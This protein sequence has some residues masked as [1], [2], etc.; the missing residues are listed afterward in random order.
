VSS[1]W[2]VEKSN[3]VIVSSLAVVRVHNKDQTGQIESPK[4]ARQQLCIFHYGNSV[5][6]VSRC[7]TCRSQLVSE[8]AGPIQAFLTLN[9]GIRS[10]EIQSQCPLLAISGHSSLC[11]FM[12]AFGGKA[13]ILMG[14][15]LCLLLTQSGHFC[16]RQNG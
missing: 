16:C 9:M 11:G 14:C 5:S 6:L 7:K 12:S 1:V 2:V 10:P 3:S 4:P 15:V 8:P 13:D